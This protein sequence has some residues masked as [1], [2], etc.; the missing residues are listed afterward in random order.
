MVYVVVQ[1]RVRLTYLT[2]HMIIIQY[3]LHSPYT[4]SLTLM[5]VPELLPE[6]RN[7]CYIYYNVLYMYYY[8]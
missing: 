8:S 2:H 3:S 1:I 7:T 4:Y 6:T 5:D